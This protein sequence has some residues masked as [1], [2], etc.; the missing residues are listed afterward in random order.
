MIGYTLFRGI[1]NIHLEQGVEDDK[2]LQEAVKTISEELIEVTSNKILREKMEI[3]YQYE[4]HYLDILK[5][6][7]EE[8]KFAASLQED[9][10]KERA[11]FFAETLKDVSD[12]LKSTEVDKNIISEWTRDLVKS[13]TKSL[14]ASSLLATEQVRDIL[15]N[16]QKESK[17]TINKAT[18]KN[19]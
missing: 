11:K 5:D 18:D 17:E 3:L 6:Y 9:I 7:K 10:R 13:Y 8:I 16:I 14:D 19:N 15:S 4:K 1:K 12:T 2:K